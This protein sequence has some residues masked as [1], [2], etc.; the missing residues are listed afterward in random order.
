MR[1]V[2]FLFF[3]SIALVGCSGMRVTCFSAM[4]AAPEAWLTESEISC[5]PAA[6]PQT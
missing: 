2:Y 4:A 5:M 6:Q 1:Y 3:A